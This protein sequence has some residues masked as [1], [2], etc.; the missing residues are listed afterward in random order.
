MFNILL[1]I[2]FTLIIF[3]THATGYYESDALMTILMVRTTIKGISP[4][5]AAVLLVVIVVIAFSA[6]YIWALG[7][8][9]AYRFALER[10]L[11]EAR[12]SS[13][14][15]V[16]VEFAWFNSSGLY[17]YVY[18]TGD[19]RMCVMDVFVNDSL[20]ARDLDWCLNPG[21]GGLLV[22]SYSFAPGDSYARVRV[23]T[24][25]FTEIVVEVYRIEG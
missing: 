5:I 3:A 25:R 6:V 11:W 20:V 4:I 16:V 2:F 21:A 19:I 9:E 13:M 8:L 18:N 15:D 24:S 14:E 12:F 7:R 23:L 17:L 22:V 10:E 1:E